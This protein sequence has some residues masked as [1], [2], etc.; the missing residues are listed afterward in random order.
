[1]EQGRCADDRVGLLPMEGAGEGG[2]CGSRVPGLGQGEPR[3]S[4]GAAQDPKD[5]VAGPLWLGL[6]GRQGL[7]L[8]WATKVRCMAVASC[9]SS[10]CGHRHLVLQGSGL[11]MGLLCRKGM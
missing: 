10:L 3:L 1:M 2:G 8:P 11:R 9:A 5:T 4:S 6:C 7:L